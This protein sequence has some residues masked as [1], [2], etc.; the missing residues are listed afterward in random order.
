M[1]LEGVIVDKVLVSIW[2]TTYNHELYIRD[3]LEGFLMQKTSFPYEIVIHDDASTDGTARIIREYERK[4]PDLIRG[5]YQEEN[6]YSK[7]HPNIKWMLEAEAQNCKGKYIAVC[8]GDDFWIDTQ[9]LQ[10][11]VDY[12]ETHPE[13]IMAVHDALNV[14][15]RNYNMK[16]GSIY[17]KDCVVPAG[18]IIVQKKYMFSASM[19]YRREVLQM[20]D[21]F[22]DAGIGDYTSMLYSL[23]V[24][25]IYYFSRIMSV[26][27]Q[28]HKGSWSDAFIQSERERWRHSILMIDFLVK[29]NEY[30]KRKFEVHVISRIQKSASAVLDS[31]NEMDEKTFRGT[32]DKYVGKL[33]RKYINIF[34]QLERLRRQLFDENFIDEAVY[35]FINKYHKIIIMG[36]GK[37]AGII[38]RQL[39]NKGVVFEGFVVSN[40]QEVEESYMN[41]PVWK[42]EMMPHDKKRTGILVGINPIIWEEIISSLNE[43]EI[44]NYICPFCWSI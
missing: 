9:K 38:A 25:D 43:A 10:L 15:C 17:E 26:Y 36:T 40:N 20:K 2:C 13:Y 4:Y 24:G 29:Y 18:D 23:T 31:C 37:Y 7:Y 33:S 22:L 35:Q 30:T 27:R 8:E 14:D 21:I 16:P 11:Q 32:Y 28:H 3:A 41:K 12:L 6:M 44:R 42:W 39:D 34:Y 19:L 1:K 5:I